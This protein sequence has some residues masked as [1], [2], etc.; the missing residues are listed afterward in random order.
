MTLDGALG[1]RACGAGRGVSML[2]PLP[3]AAA[4]FYNRSR[5][6]SPVGHREKTTT[7]FPR[8]ERSLIALSPGEGPEGSAG[9]QCC[10]TVQPSLVTPQEQILNQHRALVQRKRVVV[11]WGKWGRIKNGSQW[12]CQ[13]WLCHHCNCPSSPFRIQGHDQCSAHGKGA[14]NRQG[15]NGW[16]AGFCFIFFTC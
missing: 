3:R 1:D 10:S 13:S 8:S 2:G 14:G 11:V 5:R 4:E 7:A 9:C 12:R 6:I 16:F 15:G